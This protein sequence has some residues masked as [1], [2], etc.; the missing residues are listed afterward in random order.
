MKK[1]I[2]RKGL[3]LALL[4]DNEGSVPPRRTDEERQELYKK[5]I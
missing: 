1:T 3:S 5:F 4:F 2:L